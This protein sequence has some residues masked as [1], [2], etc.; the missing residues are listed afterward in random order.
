MAQVKDSEVSGKGV[1]ALTDIEDGTVLG[2]YPGVPR[3]SRE[4]HEKTL[5]APNSQ[6]YCY[7]TVDNIYLDP[8]DSKGVLIASKLWMM[9]DTA[10]AYINEPPSGRQTNVSFEDG[11]DDL[12]VLFVANRDI[13]MSEELF[14]DYGI[15]YDRT[16]YSRSKWERYDWRQPCARL[17][18][19]LFCWATLGWICHS[20]TISCVRLS[21]TDVHNGEQILIIWSADCNQCLR[22]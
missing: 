18:H 17:E 3:S 13:A 5:E 20:L 7:G 8:T 6:G 12:D 10:M 1:F 9:A 15:K 2:A 22:C 4:M 16:G 19:I 21:D 14:V 11:K